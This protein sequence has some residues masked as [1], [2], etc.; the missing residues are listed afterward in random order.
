M[1]TGPLYP[2]LS[3]PPVVI[4]HVIMVQYQKQ[5]IYMVKC[6]CIYF[7]ATLSCGNWLPTIS[8]MWTILSCK[9]LSCSIPLCHSCPLSPTTSDPCNQFFVL[10]LQNFVMTRM[11]YK[12]LAFLKIILH[13]PFIHVSCCRY[14]QFSHFS[15][16][17]VIVCNSIQFIY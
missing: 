13:R 10:Q 5:E 9:D 15:C 1:Q 6:M 3:F 7:C 12:W 14:Q 17:V 11:L 4:S 16:W 8:K 2:S